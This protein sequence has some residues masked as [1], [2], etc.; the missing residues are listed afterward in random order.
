M[1]VTIRNAKIEDT[2][3]IAEAEREIAKESGF[4]CSQPSEL[5]DENVKKTISDFT[6]DKT[7][8]HCF[9]LNDLI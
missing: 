7:R 1:I 3:F 2:R 5:T 6:H 9:L 4:F 8:L